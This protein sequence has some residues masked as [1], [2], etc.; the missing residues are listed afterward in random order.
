[1]N[2]DWLK[3]AWIVPMV[4]PSKLVQHSD[5]EA[6][7]VADI[8]PEHDCSQPTRSSFEDNLRQFDTMHVVNEDENAFNSFTEDPVSG[9]KAFWRTHH[10]LLASTAYMRNKCA[11]LL[12]DFWYL[13]KNLWRDRSKLVIEAMSQAHT[14]WRSGWIKASYI[15]LLQRLFRNLISK[16]QWT[17]LCTVWY[18]RSIICMQLGY[19]TSMLPPL[20][21]R[22]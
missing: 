16:E 1:M 18:L 4:S 15:K 14:R 3:M 21:C 5:W 10:A 11:F 9:T 17:R 7:F 2:A 13:M 22:W 8:S 12:L 20:Q 6:T 19:S